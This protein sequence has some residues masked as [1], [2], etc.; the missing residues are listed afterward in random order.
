MVVHLAHNQKHVGS[1][2]TPAIYPYQ[3]EINLKDVNI[4]IRITKQERF[5]LEEHGVNMGSGG[6]SAT[7]GKGFKKTY[8]L[9]ESYKNLKL[10][11]KYLESILAK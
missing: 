7:L 9:C 2:P 6:I 3:T 8:Y 11:K 5:F 10:H 1:I 4:I